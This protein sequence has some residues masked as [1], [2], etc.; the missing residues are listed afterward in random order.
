MIEENI[1]DEKVCVLTQEFKNKEAADH[2]KR[3]DITR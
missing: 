2:D 1:F 3:I